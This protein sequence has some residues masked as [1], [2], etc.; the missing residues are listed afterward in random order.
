VTEKTCP[1][2]APLC[3]NNL[4]IL[5]APNFLI[6]PGKRGNRK[7]SHYSPGGLVR[8]GHARYAVADDAAP[9]RVP[10]KPA[11]APIRAGRHAHQPAPGRARFGDSSEIWERE[12]IGPGQP[13]SMSTQ[14]VEALAG[15]FQRYESA[16]EN[17]LYRAMNQLERLQRMRLGEHIA[18]PASVDV[19]VHAAGP[20]AG[21]VG[22]FG[23]S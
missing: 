9:P 8:S 21:A 22:S 10:G 1:T 2:L 17:K 16:I 3:V 6:V 20:G 14:S 19:T 23:N 13:A 7:L 15:T 4:Y 5:Y 11:L 12:V 18:A